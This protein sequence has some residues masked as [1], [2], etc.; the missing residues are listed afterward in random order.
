MALMTS[1]D[2]PLVIQMPLFVTVLMSVCGL[3]V[4]T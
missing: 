2:H 1:G 3:S 4:V